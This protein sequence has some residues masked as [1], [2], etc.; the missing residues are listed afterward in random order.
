MKQ[1]ILDRTREAMALPELPL[2]NGRAIASLLAPLNPTMIAVALPDIRA[3]FGIG[4]GALTWLV[5]GY[6]ITVV[7]QPAGDH[8]GDA[9]GHYGGG[10]ALNLAV[11]CLMER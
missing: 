9:I 6:L 5:T 4:V 2:L 8:L 11:S 7:S 1:V 3:H 10:V